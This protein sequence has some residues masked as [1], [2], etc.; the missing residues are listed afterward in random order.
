MKT[1]S[2]PT[3][4]ARQENSSSGRGTFIALATSPGHVA[5]EE[6]GNGGI[7]TQALV[8]AIRQPGLTLN[9]VFDKVRADVDSRTGGQQLPW[10]SSSV[11]GSFQF[12]A[13]P[14]VEK[15]DS[16]T[17]SG[18]D[19][20]RLGQYTQA[21]EFFNKQLAIDSKNALALRYR[22]D[23]ELALGRT[24]KAIEDFTQA[25]AQ[26]E[27]PSEI[28]ERRAVALMRA[29]RTEEAILDLERA[30]KI[31]PTYGGAWDDLGMA[32]D[33]LGKTK[34]AL[35]SYTYAIVLNDLDAK[36]HFR[37]GRIYASIGSYD[38]A[39]KDFDAAAAVAP[40][41]QLYIE[42]SLIHLKRSQF[43]DVILDCSHAL[44]LEPAQ[45]WALNNRGLARMKLG[46]YDLAIADYT[47]SIAAD[48]EN[49]TAYRN[50]AFSY[51]VSKKPDLAAAD[52]ARALEIE[53]ETPSAAHKPVVEAAASKDA[54]AL[55]QK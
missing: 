25:I 7:F 51:R 44:E 8:G 28:Y 3:S 31:D 13:A 41:A 42:K 52:M 36:A 32:N 20:Y 27:R 10:T 14:W 15:P 22:G 55:P 19:L 9:E 4:S 39:L 11:I 48:P 16:D 30:V 29:N 26:Q 1:E 18:I 2:K 21:L 6:A 17:S 24:S 34:Q 37:R 50:R 35:E 33:K 49:S 40:S 38:D 5:E 46:Q 45:T 53:R 47:K 43:Q 12:A 23:S 54:K